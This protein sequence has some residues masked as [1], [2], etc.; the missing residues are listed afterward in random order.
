[1]DC[2][3]GRGFDRLLHP[4]GNDEQ[5]Y[6]DLAQQ[7]PQFVQGYDRSRESAAA[8]LRFIAAYRVIPAALQ[9]RV[10]ALCEPQA[11]G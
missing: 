9:E 5:R 8:I 1:M 4:P 2:L 7:L 6:P 10:L 11:R 3:S